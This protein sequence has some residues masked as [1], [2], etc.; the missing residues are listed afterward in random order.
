M[1][2][3]EDATEAVQCVQLQPMTKAFEKAVSAEKSSV[4]ETQ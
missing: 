2:E 3:V 1:N 4:T